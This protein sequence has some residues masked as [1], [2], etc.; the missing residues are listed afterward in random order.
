MLKV[1]GKTTPLTGWSAVFNTPHNAGCPPGCQGTLLAH[2]ELAVNQ[3]LQVPSH[4]AAVLPLVSQTIP[5]K[6]R[7]LVFSFVELHAID[8][9]SP[10]PYNLLSSNVET[11][12]HPVSREPVYVTVGLLQRPYLKY[13]KITSTAFLSLTRQLTLSEEIKLSRQD[14]P[15]M[16][17]H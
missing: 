3:Q 2:N 7:N 13:R 6:V 11:I 16:S 4:R 14:F 10:I 1:V 12:H 17:P 9:C 5:D 15:F 8:D